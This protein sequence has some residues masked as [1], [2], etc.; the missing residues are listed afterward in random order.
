VELRARARA[1]L[2]RALAAGFALALLI[3]AT[4]GASDLHQPHSQVKPP[5]FYR[6]SAERAIAAADRAP[7]VRAQLRH[8]RLAT[9]AYTNGIGR[10]QVSYFRHRRE[11][12]QVQVDDRSG[13]VLEQWTGPQVAWTMARG[14][15]G[16][17]GRK[18]NA[19]YLWLPLCLLFLAP[20]VDPRRPFRLLHLDLLAILGFGVSHFFF[21]RGEIATSVPLVYPVLGYLL[22]RCLAA[23]IRPSPRPN[24]L[25][26]FVPVIWLLVG[27]A[28]LGAFRIGLNV[29][30]SNVIDVGYSGV[31]GADRIVDG[32][33]IYGKGFAPGNEHG[34]TYGPVAYL[35]YVPFEQA[36]PWSG[37]WDD[38]PAA[39]A[40]A[41]TFDLLTLLA[42]YGLGRRLRD[43]P[44][45]RALGAALAY[46]W[47]ACPYTAFVLET[48]SNDG[49]V[50]LLV[51]LALLVTAP[52]ARGAAVALGGVAKFA[53]LALAPLLATVDHRRRSIGIFAVVVLVVLAA[54][55]LPFVPH[56]GLRE[57]YDRT[58]GYQIGRPSP[59][60]LWGQVPSL[61]WLQTGVKAGAVALALLLAFLPRRKDARQVAALAAAVLIAVQLGVNHWFYL[62]VVWFLPPLLVT[63]LGAY[64]DPAPMVP[65][66]EPGSAR[67][68]WP[69]LPRRPLPAPR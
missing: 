63:A 38:L 23:G 22:L 37:H 64:R 2:S 56:G 12:A 42:L 17:F 10:W 8:G 28:F 55:V 62:Y 36:L 60:S 35:A 43:G 29:T 18:L 58:F 49:L 26:P 45:G 30:D 66:P 69:A 6:L 54:T 52:G 20:F 19:P 67:S 41:I 31:V 61:G 16:A 50:A 24:R 1:R 21:N 14:Y 68:R 34:D 51:V 3:P 65:A 44:E 33:P 7:K 13:S 48:N 27:V 59:F 39:H 4:A 32:D 46:A 53:P 15:E 57:L 11:V 5:R 47:A 40:A 25:V 9:T